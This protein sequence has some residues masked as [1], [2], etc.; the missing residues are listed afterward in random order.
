MAIEPARTF[1]CTGLGTPTFFRDGRGQCVEAVNTWE[2][3]GGQE[4][5][6]NHGQIMHE[7]D[8]D[9]RPNGKP[10]ATFLRMVE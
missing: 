10:V 7:F 8:V 5:A 9:I 3:S 6:K 1:T 4:N 2:F